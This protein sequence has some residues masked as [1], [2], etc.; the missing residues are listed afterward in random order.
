M[1]FRSNQFFILE[2]SGK[3]KDNGIDRKLV[4]L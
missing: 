4:T 2:F 3:A 1:A